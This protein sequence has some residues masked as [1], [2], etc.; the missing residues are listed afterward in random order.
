MKTGRDPEP[1][2]A[3]GLADVRIIE[4]L[5]RSAETGQPVLLPAPPEGVRHPT[6]A[7]EIQ[8]PPVRE[9]ELVNAKAPHG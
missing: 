1:S 7:Q 8:R 6:L 4:A 9:P 5:Y 2:G 3:E